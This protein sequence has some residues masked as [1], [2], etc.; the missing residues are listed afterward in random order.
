MTNFKLSK[1]ICNGFLLI[2]YLQVFE[3]MYFA[4]VKNITLILC[5]FGVDHKQ[6]TK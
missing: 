1:L 2:R 4:K 5:Y 3:K 6:C